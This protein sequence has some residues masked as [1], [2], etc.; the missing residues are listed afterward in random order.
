M[1][2][3]VIPYK[4]MKIILFTFLV[5]LLLYILL[6]IYTYKTTEGFENKKKE[7]K[8][9]HLMSTMKRMSGYLLNRHTWS[10]R[11]EMAFMTPMELARRQIRLEKEK[12]K[13]Q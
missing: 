6:Y 4:N 11:L 13:F 10:E 8:L 5:L 3:N 1:R 12:T 2:E 7:N 9:L